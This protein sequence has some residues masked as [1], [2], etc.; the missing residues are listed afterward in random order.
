[1]PHQETSPGEGS[2][3]RSYD[4]GRVFKPP[5]QTPVV[6]FSFADFRGITYPDILHFHGSQRDSERIVTLR[7]VLELTRDMMLHMNSLSRAIPTDTYEHQLERLTRPSTRCVVIEDPTVEDHTRVTSYAR[8][9]LDIN[10]APDGHEIPEHIIRAAAEAGRTVIRNDR[11]FTREDHR[12][13]GERGSAMSMLMDALPLLVEDCVAV[14][15]VLVGPVD[16]LHR[17]WLDAPRALRGRGSEDMYPALTESFDWGD[18]YVIDLL[19][20]WWVFPALSEAVRYQAEQTRSSF[21]QL[22]DFQR[23]RIA[24]ASIQ[25]PLLDR[26]VL[27]LSDSGDGMLLGSV[28]PDLF[29]HDVAPGAEAKAAGGEKLTNVERHNPDLSFI[30]GLNPRSLGS[31]YI[32]SQIDQLA[33][34]GAGSPAENIRRSLSLLTSLLQTGGKL[35]M[36]TP[37]APDTD[38]RVEFHVR[39]DDGASSGTDP[40]ILS[41]AA[42]FLDFLEANNIPDEVVDRDLGLAYEGHSHFSCPMSLV[43]RFLIAEEWRKDWARER[44]RNVTPLSRTELEDSLRCQNLRIIQSRPEYDHAKMSRWGGKFIITDAD[45]IRLPFPPSGYHVVGERVSGTGGV[46]LE[47][48]REPVVAEEPSFLTAS[49]YSARDVSQSQEP[50]V[51][52]QISTPGITY[53]LFPVVTDPANHRHAFYCKAGAPRP[54]STMGSRPLDGLYHTGYRIE[55]LAAVLKEDLFDDPHKIISDLIETLDVRGGIRP[56]RLKGIHASQEYL[57][58]PTMVGELVRSVFFEVRPGVPLLHPRKRDYSGFRNS[59]VVPLIEGTQILRACQTGGMTDAR[60]ERAVYHHL[61]R[62]NA[63]IGPWAG[64]KLNLTAQKMPEDFEAADVAE[65][66]RRNNQVVYHKLPETSLRFVEVRQG[67]FVEKDGR[68]RIVGGK[69]VS[70]EYALPS[71]ESGMST[72]ALS[73]LPVMKLRRDDEIS[74]YAG[75][76]L[77]DMPAAQVHFQ[78]ST[79]A[80]VPFI[81]I[82][83]DVATLEDA[84]A[85]GLDALHR[86]FNLRRGYI[87]SLS[88]YH[89]T[90]GMTPDLVYPHIVEVDARFAGEAEDISWVPLDELLDMDT[91]VRCGQLLTLAYRFRHG[92]QAG[93]R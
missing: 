33:E 15:K 20:R 19:F 14:Q 22:K 87:W 63:P 18:G 31:V 30:E 6:A 74:Y 46:K 39:S 38:E 67:D 53:D 66:L 56:G 76:Q 69:T 78:N 24:V 12:H 23:Q 11:I 50:E 49:C 13:I 26:P 81:R 51:V 27:S 35:I 86:Y 47:A 79:V 29:V 37:L 45:G 34:W 73:F 9:Y 90:P 55:E 5:V 44:S 64:P 48:F 91:S 8:A 52:E 58:D 65:L 89:P 71:S 32:S 43:H 70:L 1:M 17:R 28:R 88:P 25:V 21:A 85:Y 68:G 16:K 84:Q 93:L 62:E 92:C 2:S 4:L 10:D 59:G 36:R 3:R 80:T 77:R 42:L 57:T 7:G 41:S 61:L 40:S 54:V 82:P 75:I 60:L 72:N 83:G